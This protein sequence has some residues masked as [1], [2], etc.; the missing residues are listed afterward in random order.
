MSLENIADKTIKE[1]RM[2][3]VHYQTINNTVH[4]YET[5]FNIDVILGQLSYYNNIL[6]E[7]VKKLN[8]GKAHRVR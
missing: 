2:K 5:A 4:H 7:K 3:H 6:K 1:I 8:K